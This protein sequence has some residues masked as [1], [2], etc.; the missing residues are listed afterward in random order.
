VLS[1]QCRDFFFYFNALQESFS[2][3]R[4]LSRFGAPRFLF[5]F[6]NERLLKGMKFRKSF[7]IH[8]SSG[9]LENKHYG[10]NKAQ[11]HH[12]FRNRLKNNHSSSSFGFFL[13]PSQ[14]R[15][16]LSLPA[17]MRLRELVNPTASAAAMAI[18]AFSIRFSS[19]W[20]MR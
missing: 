12:R 5:V 9:E 8:D 14:L 13:Q 11:D 18:I 7:L 15:R 10:D 19:S 20:R 17:H 6:F 2:A 3:T 16:S 1:A 4:F